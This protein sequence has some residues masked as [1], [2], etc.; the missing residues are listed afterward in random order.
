M[1][2]VRR[3]LSNSSLIGITHQV[4]PRGFSDTEGRTVWLRGV[5]EGWTETHLLKY[6]DRFVD[7]IESIDQIR[8]S[9]DV[10]QDRALIRFKD[11]RAAEEFVQRYHNDY[12]NSID[13]KQ[14]LNCSIYS[15]KRASA[16]IDAKN[17]PTEVELYNLPFEATNLDILRLAGEPTPAKLQMPQ[18]TS[19]LNKGFCI[20]SFE[21]PEH[22]KSFVEKVQ[23]LTLMGRRLCAR[24]KFISFVTHKPSLKTKSDELFEQAE[25]E[26]VRIHG[27]LMRSFFK[28]HPQAFRDTN[29]SVKASN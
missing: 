21:K 10:R 15:L 12:I 13:V 5:P 29:G 24:Q 25:S 26:E 1:K 27:S 6:F 18:R 17:A 2:N 19:Q 23:G 20:L 3:W 14:R 4:Q 11:P 9:L 7:K 28:A 16:R 8:N 22:A